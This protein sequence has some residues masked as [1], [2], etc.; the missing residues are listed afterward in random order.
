M[1]PAAD[2]ARN[3]ALALDAFMAEHRGC[4]RLYGEG[5]ETGEDGAVVWLTCH[6]CIAVIRLLR[7]A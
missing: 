1:T 6:G 4:W 7:P 2:D 3:L 5:F